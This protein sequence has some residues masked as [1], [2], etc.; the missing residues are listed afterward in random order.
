MTSPDD[1]RRRDHPQAH[2]SAEAA[3]HRYDDRAGAREPRQPDRADHPA[4]ITK[5]LPDGAARGRTVRGLVAPEVDLRDLPAFRRQPK[6]PADGHNPAI[7]LEPEAP[8]V[9]STRIPKYR[10]AQF[11]SL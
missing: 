10:K 2:S 3:G 9:T 5:H 7:R 1:N 4:Q 11:E 6:V 8:E